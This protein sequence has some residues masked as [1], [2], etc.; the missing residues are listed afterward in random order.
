MVFPPAVPAKAH[1]RAPP[2][3]IQEAQGQQAQGEEA[4]V[5]PVHPPGPEA[6]GQRGP[7]GLSLRQATASAAA[8]PPAADTEPAAAAL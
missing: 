8:V 5:P 3:A 7:H 6:G 1:L 2:S 4:E